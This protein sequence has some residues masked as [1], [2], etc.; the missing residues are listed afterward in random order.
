[1]HGLRGYGRP[2]WRLL[3]LAVLAV[4]LASSSGL[5]RE[6]TEALPDPRRM[7]FEPVDFHPPEPDR[8]VLDNG[9]VVYLLEDHELPLVTVSA[10]FRTGG[11]LDPAGKVGL[12]SLTGTVMRTGGTARMTAEEVDKT[13]EHIA[14]ELSVG[15]GATS[16]SAMLDVLKKD[17]ET[18]LRIFADVL[19]TPRFDPDRLE[20]AKLQLLESIRRR[21]DQPES[22]AARHFRKLLYGPAH[23]LARESSI[24]SIS[25]LT[26]DDLVRFH[27]DTLHPN[28][29]ILGVTGD[30]DGAQMLGSLRTLFGDWA[31]GEVPALELPPVGAGAGQPG[32]NG[33]TIVRYVGKDTS[34]A[35]LRVGHLTL[36]EDHPDYPA[37]AIANDILGGSSFRSRLFRDVRTGEGLAYSVGS[38]LRPGIWASGVWAMYAETKLDST[39]RVIERLIAN[40]ERLRR[41]PVTE[42]ELKEAKESFVNSFV[43]S[44]TS[45]SRIVNRLMS[46][47]Y[48]GLPKNFL[49]QLRDKVVKLTTR[50]LARAARTHLNP[51]RLKILAVGP[52]QTLP[53]M[54]STFGRVQEIPIE[55]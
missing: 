45:P 18:G 52:G 24:E 44:F 51:A 12:A 54:L 41:E 40:L 25:G 22:I 1:M 8:V 16:G 29:L 43:F 4:A 23:P 38:V 3:L 39:G 30:F 35:H 13:L 33:E 5:A 7:T 48:D 14:A 28:G 37:L 26:R 21:N 6:V 15:I 9:L 34:Q 19:R 32:L 36:K 47:E 11:W 55:E 20:L 27:R 49:E 31:K 42:A 10:I 53:G 17:L 46:L 50:D 2:P